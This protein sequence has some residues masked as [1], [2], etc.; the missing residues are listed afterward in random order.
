MLGCSETENEPKPEAVAAFSASQTTITTGESISFTNTSQNAEEYQWTFQGGSPSTSTSKSPTITYNNPG[1][2][3]V[4]LTASNASSLDT[5]T[6]TSYITVSDPDPVANFTASTTT[7]LVGSSVV[8]TNNSINSTSYSWQF[9]GGSPSTSLTTNPTVTYNSTG[10]FDVTL[11][12]SNS[13][14]QTDT[15]TKPNM[16]E[17]IPNPVAAFSLSSNSI[18][19]G[20]SITIDNL[21]TDATSF[22]WVF[23]GG[24][25]STS[26]ASDPGEITFSTPGN[27][28]IQLT[29]SNALGSD[30]EIK[31]ITVNESTTFDL[32]MQNLLYFGVYIYRDGSYLGYISAR[33]N[34]TFSNLSRASSVGIT[35]DLD[36]PVG[37]GIDLGASWTLNDPKGE[38]GLEI[39]NIIGSNVYQYIMIENPE[40][41]NLFTEVNPGTGDLYSSGNY[42]VPAYS[43]PTYIG[44]AKFV[45]LSQQV[46][47]YNNSSRTSS[48]WYLAYDQDVLDE[49]SGR[50]DI[51]FD[52]TGSWDSGSWNGSISRQSRE[53]VYDPNYRSDWDIELELADFSNCTIPDVEEIQIK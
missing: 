29:A 42:Y 41:Y 47:L 19:E 52:I 50:V 21:S 13:S 8:F 32:T 2:F 3:T 53:I 30:V 46:H 16:I 15:E 40:P 26:T 11:T 28:T 12:A 20:E 38:I 5:E 14:G 44:Y 4:S 10:S 39:D 22:E 48:Y 49:G 18:T 9:E 25:P 27:Y 35:W 43:G 17:V 51:L 37:S 34:A 23:N 31:N 24:S 7:I 45:E 6:K 36:V 33:S 1:V